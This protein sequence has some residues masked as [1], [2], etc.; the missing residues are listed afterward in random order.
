M[1]VVYE[2]SFDWNEW[3]V[4][5]VL[6]SL[7]GLMIITPKIF[8]KTEGIAHYLYGITIVYLFDHTLSTKPW[9]FYDVNDNSNF[10]LF[11]FLYY[12]MNGPFS[13][14]FIY[15]YQKLKID[16]FRTILYLLLWSSLAVLMEWVGFKIGLFH[17]DK[18]Y[19]MHWSF[20]IYMMVQIIQIIFY[21]KIRR[22]MN[23]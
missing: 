18:G 17:Y 4:I 8:S 3:F 14:Y 23:H 21:H 10:Q 12:I 20:P 15:L 9:D 7:H 22:S 13:Y 16:G 2:K 1:T 6:I 11:D 5:I 19:N